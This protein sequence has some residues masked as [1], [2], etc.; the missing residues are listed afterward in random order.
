MPTT[1]T[2]PTPPLLV[3]PGLE[4]KQWTLTD[5]AID[6]VHRV[7]CRVRAF[8]ISSQASTTSATSGTD[9][10]DMA[11]PSRC[12]LNSEYD[13][14]GEDKNIDK[15]NIDGAVIGDR[16]KQTNVNVDGTDSTNASNASTPTT[17]R[18]RLFQ[19]VQRKPVTL[20]LETFDNQDV[21]VLSNP[22]KNNHGNHSSFSSSSSSSSSSMT[23]SSTMSWN[24]HPSSPLPTPPGSPERIFT[25]VIRR[26]VTLPHSRSF[27]G[28]LTDGEDDDNNKDK[29]EEEASSSSSSSSTSSSP[30]PSYINGNKSSPYNVLFDRVRRK[31]SILPEHK[32][33]GRPNATLITQERKVAAIPL[34]LPPSLTRTHSMDNDYYSRPPRQSKN[35][36]KASSSSSSSS[37]ISSS[38]SS[39]SSSSTYSPPSELNIPQGYHVS[40]VF[41]KHAHVTVAL[42]SSITDPTFSVVLKQIYLSK[43]S[44]RR[45]QDAALSERRAHEKVGHHPFICSCLG[46]YATDDGDLCLLLKY[47]RGGNL[48]QYIRNKGG[49]SVNSVKIIFAQIVSA[50]SHCHQKKVAHRD[51]KPENIMLMTKDAMIDD[52]KNDAQNKN[53]RCHIALSDFGLA[54]RKCSWSSGA[55][56]CCGTPQY[57]SPEVA[58]GEEHGLAVDCWSLGILLWEMLVGYTPFQTTALSSIKIVQMLQK[59]KRHMHIFSLPKHIIA[60]PELVDLLNHLLVANVSKR[61]TLESV[62]AS[63]FF[64]GISWSEMAEGRSP[65]VRQ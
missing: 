21:F 61:W 62:K 17:S 20:N 48:L 16:A 41:L 57:T 22:E 56:D 46:A 33:N 35:S 52:A 27:S 30:I 14:G 58:R 5:D 32:T 65:Q 59:I 39:S 1:A 23:S 26:T 28:D 24:N 11:S 37:S 49:M 53:R 19:R 54:R 7:Q 64:H 40:Y 13:G 18:G 44:D 12:S 9:A 8:S 25:K 31:T 51:L 43:T 42:L 15:Y 6:E 60:P 34:N 47:C 29:K 45:V 3:L 38:S 2:Q 63:S 50:L 10:F 4:R 36:S 55:K